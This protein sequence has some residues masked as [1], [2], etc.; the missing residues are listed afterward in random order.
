[1][2]INGLLP[3]FK[4]I[5]RPSHISKYRG[6]KVAVDGYSWLHKGAYACSRELCEGTWTDRWVLGVFRRVGVFCITVV[7]RIAI[8][9]HHPLLQPTNRRRHRHHQKTP[10]ADCP[11][12]LRF[13][14]YFLSRVRLL[15]S[16]GVAPLIVFDGGRLPIKGDEEESRRRCAFCGERV[17]LFGWLVGLF[18]LLGSSEGTRSMRCF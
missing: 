13:V 4:G 2:G 9:T 18:W 15:T 6:E 3:A 8:A 11:M 16:H 14:T 17:C 10:R 5:C 12:P 1:M 7:S